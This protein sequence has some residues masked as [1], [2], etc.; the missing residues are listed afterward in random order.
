MKVPFVDFKDMHGEIRDDL[1]QAY[2]KV[3]DSN[4]F[5]GGSSIKVR[6]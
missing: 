5:I 1:D 4:W 3:M 6:I 2:K